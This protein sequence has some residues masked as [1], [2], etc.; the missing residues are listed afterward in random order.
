M[1]Q[2]IAS[3]MLSSDTGD[4]YSVCNTCTL[5]LVHIA[6][7]RAPWFRLIREPLHLGMKIM[8]W[9]HKVDPRKYKVY[10]DG[11]YCCIR[12]TKTGLKERSA[13]FRWLNDRINPLID[14]ILETAV[15]EEEIAIANRYAYHATQCPEEGIKLND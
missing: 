9:W 12:F 2:R 1:G 5:Q 3:Q 4:K 11:C 7:S 13:L 6:Y 8:G 10:T 14:R 15:S